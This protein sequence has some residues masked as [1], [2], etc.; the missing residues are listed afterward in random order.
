MEKGNVADRKK[1]SL[2]RYLM[3]KVE[4]TFFFLISKA[5]E[6]MSEEEINRIIESPDHF[7]WTFFSSVCYLSEKI[8]E[9]ILNRKIEVAFVD[10]KWMTPIFRFESNFEKMLQKRINPFVVGYTGKSW[11]ELRNFENVDQTLL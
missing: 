6:K 7:G 8:S 1:H 5:E 3:S 10:D 4:G 2:F 9:W 11:F